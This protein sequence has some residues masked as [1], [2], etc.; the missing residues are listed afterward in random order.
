LE[1]FGDFK[2]YPL[3]VNYCNSCF[4]AQLS[5]SVNPDKLFRNYVYV[6]G[7][8]KTLDSYFEDFVEKINKINLPSK[9]ILEIASNDG[10]L[11]HKLKKSGWN[12][13][14]VDPAINLLSASIPNGLITIPNYFNLDLTQFLA[15]DFSLIVGMN[16]FA[17]TPNPLEI[18]LAAKNILLDDGLILIQTSQA[19]MIN[20]GQFDT[21]YHE[22]I[23][24]FNVKS[25]Q[26]IVERAGL[27][28][29]GL[30]MVPIH[31]NSYLWYITKKPRK[32]T[33]SENLKS[34]LNFEVTQGVYE[35]NTYIKYSNSAMQLRTLVKKNIQKY[36]EKNYSIAVYGAA[37]KGNTFINYCKIDVD[38]VYDDNILKIGK[39]SPINGRV[40]EDPSK[41]VKSEGKKL[42]ILTAWNFKDEI[43]S[44]IKKM[45]T[46]HEDYYLVYY[47]KLEIGKIND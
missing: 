43:I 21:V 45:R 9:K 15:T 39:Y 38:E 3:S 28:L 26:K 4:H 33:T 25:M 18:L 5:F 1:S 14:G 31:G 41:L 35:K 42:F 22:H 44:K 17:H 29:S 40:V 11:I 7:T 16:V 46:N 13:V 12:A 6:S 27:F 37:A 32:L 8:T 19:D 30:E 47:P 20:L 36:A 23:S 10:S 2:E 24:F 34:R